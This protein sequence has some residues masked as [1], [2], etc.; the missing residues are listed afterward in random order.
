VAA[1]SVGAQLVAANLELDELIQLVAASSLTPMDWIALGVMAF[2]LKS[3]GFHHLVIW[4]SDKSKKASR[5]GPCND[6][7][8]P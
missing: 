6:E 4:C 5:N 3:L 1:N 8:M 2:L 7:T